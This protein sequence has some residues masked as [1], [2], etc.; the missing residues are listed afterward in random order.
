MVNKGENSLPPADAALSQATNP[1]PHDGLPLLLLLVPPPPPPPPLLLLRCPANAVA[2]NWRVCAFGL[3][4]AK[5]NAV[6][7]SFDCAIG[8]CNPARSV[9]LV[10]QPLEGS[11]NRQTHTRTHTNTD[12]IH[13]TIHPLPFCPSCVCGV[14]LCCLAIANCEWRQRAQQSTD[15][16]TEQ[17]RSQPAPQHRPCPKRAHTQFQAQLTF[18]SNSCESQCDIGRRR[19]ANLA[20]LAQPTACAC[21]SPVCLSLCRC[22][23]PMQPAWPVPFAKLASSFSA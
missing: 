1:C 10:S 22:D 23:T 18:S 21:V 15:N 5:P 6:S 12:S 14:G 7:C 17:P 4:H 19:L 13:Q 20:K 2:S 3:P 9:T 8:Q 11:A 16:E